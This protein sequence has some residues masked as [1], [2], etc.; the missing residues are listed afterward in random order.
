MVT[1][2]AAAVGDAPNKRKPPKHRASLAPIQAVQG[3]SSPFRYCGDFAAVLEKLAVDRFWNCPEQRVEN[4]YGSPI[5]ALAPQL[6]WEV[7]NLVEEAFDMVDNDG[8]GVVTNRELVRVMELLNVQKTEAWATAK[9]ASM[10][11]VK[12]TAPSMEAGL[13]R[14]NATFA[15]TEEL[16]GGKKQLIS[17]PQVVRCVADEVRAACARAGAVARLTY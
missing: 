14:G 4:E 10:S 7:C 2:G 3:K 5:T 13:V 9:I 15:A 16:T 8:N 12:V 6:P 11:R 1:G 17:L